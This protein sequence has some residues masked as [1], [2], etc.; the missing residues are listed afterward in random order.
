MPNSIWVNDLV[1][2]TV[3]EAIKRYVP[4]IVAARKNISVEQD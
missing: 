2:D 1:V 4:Q 3:Y